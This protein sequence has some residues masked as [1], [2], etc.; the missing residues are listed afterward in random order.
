MMALRPWLLEA[1]QLLGASLLLFFLL[2]SDPRPRE[3]LRLFE[4]LRELT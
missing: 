3:R 1:E 2:F 4:R